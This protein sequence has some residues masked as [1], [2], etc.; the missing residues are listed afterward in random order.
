MKYHL[1]THEQSITEYLLQIMLKDN[2][3]SSAVGPP[4]N[5]QCRGTSKCDLIG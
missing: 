4:H 5:T 3:N 2:N 1:Q